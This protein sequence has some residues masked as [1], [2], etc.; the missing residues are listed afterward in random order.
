MTCVRV[1]AYDLRRRNVDNDQ[2]PMPSYYTVKGEPI[3]QSWRYL[4]HVNNEQCRNTQFNKEILT[5]NMNYF[6][7]WNSDNDIR[8]LLPSNKRCTVLHNSC[9]RCAGNYVAAPLRTALVMGQAVGSKLHPHPWLRHCHKSWFFLVLPSSTLKNDTITFFPIP[10]KLASHL[11][12][13]PQSIPSIYS[14]FN[15]AFSVTP[16]IQRTINGW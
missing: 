13:Y 14:S 5:L 7:K 2:S 1:S 12:R 8:V 10:S 9:C 4:W 3:F 16:I 6:E 15:D 11:N